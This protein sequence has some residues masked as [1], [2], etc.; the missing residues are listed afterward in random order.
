MSLT[1][2]C[3]RK[4]VLAWMLLLAVVLGGGLA[5]SRIGISS[6][7]DV[8]L[9]VVA[10]Q[11]VWPGAAPEVMEHD[12]VE[13]I[14]EAISQI[15]GIAHINSTARQGT[16]T[17]QLELALDRSA[18]D[19]KQEVS[20]RIDEIR[21]LLPKDLEDPTVVKL[22]FDDFPILWISLSGPLS[23]QELA[24]IAR[25]TAAMEAEADAL[26]AWALAHPDEF[27]KRKSL[28]LASA[29]IGFRTDPPKVALLN[30][31]WT[32]DKV[33]SLLASQ[34]PHLVRVKQEVNKEAILDSYSEDSTDLARFGLRITQS[35][36]F[37]VEAKLTDSPTTTKH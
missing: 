7:P 34:A 36:Q 16:A 28:D 23:R 2:A 4:P 31:S 33:T 30:R 27:T 14:E 25:Y 21:P 3:I 17:I 12:V 18:D 35:E 9:P 13:P 22:N 5:W 24:D 32:W 6:L 11:L 20:A 1:D 19:V 10:M 29:V 8:D 26:R 15:E 37:F